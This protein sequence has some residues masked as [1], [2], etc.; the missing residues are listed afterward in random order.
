MKED[1]G[2]LDKPYRQCFY[3]I[4]NDLNPLRLQFTISPLYSEQKSLSA[5]TNG[6]R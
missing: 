3:L 2:V 5:G 6:G 1:R 4:I